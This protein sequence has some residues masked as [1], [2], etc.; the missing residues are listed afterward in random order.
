MRRL[1]ALI[2]LVLLAGCKQQSFDD[3]YQAAQKKIEAKTASM[4]K[5]LAA[6]ESDAAAAG[7]LATDAALPEPSGAP[8]ENAKP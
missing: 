2:A 7:V 3:R 6:A 5:D 4:D 1:A 8:G